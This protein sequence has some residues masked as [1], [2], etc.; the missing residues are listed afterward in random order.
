M[1]LGG[2][3]PDSLIEFTMLGHSGGVDKSETGEPAEPVK[4]GPQ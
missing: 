3:L 2:N 1:Q 4:N